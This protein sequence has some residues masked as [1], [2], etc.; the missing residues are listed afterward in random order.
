MSDFV[1]PDC[2]GTA[3]TAWGRSHP[4]M[5]HWRLNPG[6]AINEVLLGQRVGP[7]WFCSTC[8]PETLPNVPMPM[9]KSFLRCGECR[10]FI[11]SKEWIGPKAFENYDGLICPQCGGQVEV[12]RNCLGR[13]IDSLRPRAKRQQQQH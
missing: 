4:V 9:K 10:V 11:S 3:H 5:I 1:C 6:L 2:G 13:L 8:K 12:V 7:T